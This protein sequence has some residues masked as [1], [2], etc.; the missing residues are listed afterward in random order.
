MQH[1]HNFL[2]VYVRSIPTDI[3]L[4][5]HTCKDFLQEVVSRNRSPSLR[6]YLVKFL[7]LIGRK[8]Q[9]R[10]RPVDFVIDLLEAKN[11]LFGESI[12]CMS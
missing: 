5:D 7:G 4:S 6:S 8:Y 1:V 9:E 2:K 3:R 11:L 12:H 10:G